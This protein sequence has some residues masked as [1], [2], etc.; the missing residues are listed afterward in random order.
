MRTEKGL[1]TIL[2]NPTCT[3][4]GRPSMRRSKREGLLE[5]KVLAKMGIYPW[6]C[7]GCQRRVLRLNSGAW[8]FDRIV[9]VEEYMAKIIGN[10]KEAD[11][12][13]KSRHW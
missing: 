13:L 8:Q 3:A 6:K 10:E 12:K 11:Q 2:P 9:R 1:R 4:C 7:S 5:R